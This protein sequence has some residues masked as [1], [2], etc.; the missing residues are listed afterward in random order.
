MLQKEVKACEEKCFH[1]Q[2]KMH[3]NVHSLLRCSAV[4]SPI[5]ETL[6]RKEHID[7]SYQE[8]E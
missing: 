8:K 4:L 7:F 2:G 5:T 6:L 1:N 3:L